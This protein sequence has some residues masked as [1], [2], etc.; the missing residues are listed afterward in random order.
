MR[1]KVAPVAVGRCAVTELPLAFAAL[2]A[3]DAALLGCHVDA[4]LGRTGRGY[5]YGYGYCYAASSCTA[6][7]PSARPRCLAATPPL[8]AGAAPP[9]YAPMDPGHLPRAQ[10]GLPLARS[11]LGFGT[12]M[13]QCIILTR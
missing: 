8:F 9:P 10:R 2:F 11:K 1:N 4:L 6:A 3:Q 7:T 13:P 5:G 12:A